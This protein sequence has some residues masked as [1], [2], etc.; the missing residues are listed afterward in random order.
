MLVTSVTDKSVEAP[1]MQGRAAAEN[2]WLANGE[3]CDSAYMSQTFVGLWLLMPWGG[4][5]LKRFRPPSML[6]AFNSLWV[7]LQRDANLALAATPRPPPHAL[8][9]DPEWIGSSAMHRELGLCLV[10]DPI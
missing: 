9:V 6:P 5:G 8:R 4:G 1:G 2:S 10:V 7:V 3:A